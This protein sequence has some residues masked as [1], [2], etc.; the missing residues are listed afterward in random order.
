MTA[1]LPGVGIGGLFY[2][3][4]ALLMPF[5]ATW[6]AM[7][8]RES[9]WALALRQALIAAGTLGA[10]WATGWGVGWLIAILTPAVTGAGPAAGS[11]VVRSVVQTATFLGTIGTLIVVLALVQVLRVVLPPQATAKPTTTETPGKIQSAA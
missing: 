2:L 11:A 8:G 4:S 10:L 3:A 9:R 7:R 5:R 6:N 1:G